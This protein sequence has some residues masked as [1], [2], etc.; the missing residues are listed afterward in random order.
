V[1]LK[2]QLSQSEDACVKAEVDLKDSHRK[3]SLPT[4]GTVIGELKQLS[5]SKSCPLFLG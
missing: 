5:I 2:A 3:C 1:T 4:E